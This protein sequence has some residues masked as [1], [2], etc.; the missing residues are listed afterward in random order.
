MNSAR[1]RNE[2]TLGSV[3]ST[4]SKAA[5]CDLLAT[6][7]SGFSPISCCV[8]GDEAPAFSSRDGQYRNT[9]LSHT[10]GLFLEEVA[11]RKRSREFVCTRRLTSTMRFAA[12]QIWPHSMVPTLFST[13]D[14]KRSRIAPRAPWQLSR[15]SL[16]TWALPV[17]LGAA[18]LRV[19]EKSTSKRPAPRRHDEYLWYHRGGGVVCSWGLPAELTGMPRPT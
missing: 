11:R 16:S 17:E 8:G 5:P 15:K 6:F 2:S 9:G 7:R 4:S 3:C 13:H 1:A 12:R 14:T 18:I 10:T 19:R